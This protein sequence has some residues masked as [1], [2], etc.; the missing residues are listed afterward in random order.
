MR[1]CQVTNSITLK[2]SFLTVTDTIVPLSNNSQS[3]KLILNV[4][5]FITWHWQYIHLVSVDYTIRIIP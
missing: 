2:I 1:Y 3:K 4:I 5:E